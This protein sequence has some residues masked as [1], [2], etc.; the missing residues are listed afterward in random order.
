MINIY[1]VITITSFISF[2]E[3]IIYRRKSP[4]SLAHN[5]ELSKATINQLIKTMTDSQQLSFT[6]F[7]II[8]IVIII[9][10]IITI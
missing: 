2:F 1:I 9:I 10:L 4:P 8:T 7:F 5:G 6:S 3:L